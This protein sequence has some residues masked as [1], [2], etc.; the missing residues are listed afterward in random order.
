[1]TITVAA[2]NARIR[3]TATSSQTAFAIPFEFFE[4]DEIHVYVGDTALVAATERGQGT[5]S[6]E[7]GISG[8]GGSTGAIAFVTGITQGHIVTIVRDIPIERI[9][10]FT[11]GT[12]INRAALNTQLDTLT[13]MVGDLKDKSD[14]AIRLQPYDSEITLFLPTINNRAGKIFGF[15]ANGN[16]T[17]D[18]SAN[19]DITLDDVV[20]NTLTMAGNPNSKFNLT[21]VVD[22]QI[23]TSGAVMNIKSTK[24][25]N[26]AT[27]SLDGSGTYGIDFNA[28]DKAIRMQDPTLFGSTVEVAGALT[29]PLIVSQSG[30]S[31]TLQPTGNQVFIKGTSGESRITFHNP[32]APSMEFTGDSSL[33]GSGSFLLDITDEIILDSASGSLLLKD[34]GVLRM[35]LAFNGSAQSI[36]SVNGLTI[37]TSSGALNFKPYTSNTDFL[38]TS[39]DQVIQ[40][41]C[42]SGNGAL[43][44]FQNSNTTSLKAAN[45]TGTRTLLLPDESGTIHSSGGAT[46]H[47]NITVSTDGKVQFRDSAIYIQSGADGHLDLV[48]DTEIHIAATTV[49]VDGLMDVSGNLSVGGNFDVTGTIDFSD[50]NITNVGSI[51]LDKL[52]ND[53]G[54]GITL[55]SS[56]G[57]V[58]DSSTGQI[59]FKDDNVTRLTVAVNSGST[60]SI[61]SLAGLKLNSG[62]DIILE[63]D[64]GQVYI[65]DPNGNDNFQFN[66]SSTPTL[67]IHQNSNVTNLGL[68]NPTATRTILFP[69][70]SDTLVGKATT[71]TLT[72]KT[73]TAP[74][75][76][77][78]TV[79]ASLDI[80]G[81][82]DVDG[83]TNLDIV[84][85]DGAV[86][87]AS[88]LQVDGAITSNGNLTLSSASSPTLRLTDTTN[89]SI[90]DIRAND[91][92]VLI[93]STSN[94]PMILNTNQTNRMQ[95]AANGDISFFDDDGSTVKFFFDASSGG[96][97]IGGT[98]NVYSGYTNLTLNHATN[99][100]IIDLELNGAVIGEFFI[101]ANGLSIYTPVSNDDIFFKGNDDGGGQFTALTLDMSDAGTAI[102][103]HDATFAG[104]AS[105]AGTFSPSN[106]NWTTAAFKGAGSYGGALA[107]V[108]GDAGYATYVQSS[109]ATYVIA[110][111]ATS[112]AVTSKLQINSGNVSITDGNLVVAAGH[113]ID[114]AAQTSADSV[115][116]VST[117]SELLDHYEEGTW[118]PVAAG[119]SLSSVSAQYT[120]IGDM[121]HYGLTVTLP[122]TTA[123]THL[124][125]TGLPF[126]VAAN[127]F[128]GSLIFTSSSV[129]AVQVI[130]VSSSDDVQLYK[131]GGAFA[132]YADFNGSIVR[133]SGAYKTDA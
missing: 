47:A 98:P 43:K 48:A 57:I 64:G 121:V 2:N 99:G 69:D 70:A 85:I 127:T 131:A 71:D 30:G 133:V 106:S 86:D 18:T 72:N 120:R 111:G 8:G 87:M 49:N 100:G 88:T 130:A 115:T 116:G 39:G 82:I 73:L 129:T 125:F 117:G 104:T 112:G 55:D 28:G 42:P 16:L 56:A 77:G 63:A 22:S 123:T 92:D 103:N 17:A 84:D 114:F 10:D 40:I 89:T 62:A 79:V 29:A 119:L 54:G 74:T 66:G 6:T 124:K 14:R 61:T 51:S 53:G 128:G 83:T 108:D 68:V 107:L 19:F 132:T 75:L 32:A 9:T 20:S 5:G 25:G 13:A 67:G 44:F 93:R 37:G 4:N 90:F 24:G 78:T 34:A 60:Q 15:D 76:T 21:A 31:I 118:T 52:T 45:P 38:T 109:G 105:A 23:V 101:D 59:V 95:I 7:Y 46:T 50:A 102:F 110:Q 3:Y 41:Q 122:T 81:D 91:S 94:H 80:S 11:A 27:I 97:G 26:T 65:T 113:G 126:S 1:M 36:T 33:I 96:V 12:T 35:T 58:I